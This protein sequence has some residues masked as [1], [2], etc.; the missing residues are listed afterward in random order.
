M[1]EIKVCPFCGG[2]AK[3]EP[4]IDDGYFCIGCLNDECH[5]EI[6]PKGGFGYES[7]EKAI[8]SWNTRTVA[9]RR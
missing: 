1:E 3:I 7:K 6:M 9:T 2:K 4:W 5:G 8:K